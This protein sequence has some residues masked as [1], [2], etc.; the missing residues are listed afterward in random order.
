MRL[1]HMAQRSYRLTSENR[2]NSRNK[3]K[4]YEN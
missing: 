3:Y 4:K 2:A 1:K